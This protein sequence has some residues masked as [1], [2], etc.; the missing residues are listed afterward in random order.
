MLFDQQVELFELRLHGVDVSDI[1][2]HYLDEERCFSM[3]VSA[4]VSQHETSARFVPVFLKY[5]SYHLSWSICRQQCQDI[6]ERALSLFQLRLSG[7]ASPLGPMLL[8]VA[9]S[10]ACRPSFPRSTSAQSPSHCT[11]LQLH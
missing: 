4:P 2:V 7:F 1:E 9:P 6:V 3:R 5:F 11:R 10:A 8:L